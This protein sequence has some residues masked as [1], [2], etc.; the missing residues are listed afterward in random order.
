[1]PPP[2]TARALV[3]DIGGV[4][5]RNARELVLA[6]GLGERDDDLWQAMLRHEVSERD[7]WAARA[8]TI[9]SELG[10]PEWSTRE[11]MAWLYH[12]PDADFLV[13]EMIELMVDTRS[14]GLPLV[15]LTNDM[16]AFHGQEWVDRQDWL[17]HFDTIVDGSVIGVLKPDP[18]AYEH[19]VAA[20]G[21]P[22]AETVFLD[23][24]PW[25]LAGALA[26]GMQAVEVV[27]DDRP[28]A[29]ASAR[30][31]LGLRTVDH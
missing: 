21:V 7:Y 25:N 28:A 12:Q 17:K 30:R 4:V 29:V 6:R 24:M 27:Y 1:M 10:H 31:R 22:A 11:L 15:A 14:A 5:L 16:V 3:L 23:D 20:T 13:D 18:A 26:V 2:R 8:G 19:A 9:G